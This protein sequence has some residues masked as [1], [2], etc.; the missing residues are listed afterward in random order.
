M[1][2]CTKLHT[3]GK[4]WRLCCIICKMLLY[5]WKS[6]ANFTAANLCRLIVFAVWTHFQKGDV[7]HNREKSAHTHLDSL[8]PCDVA[9]QSYFQQEQSSLMSIPNLSKC[10]FSTGT[11]KQD[12]K[13]SILSKN[14]FLLHVVPA[15]LHLSASIDAQGCNPGWLH[16]TSQ[17]RNSSLLEA[18]KIKRPNTRNQQEIYNWN[19]KIKGY[20]GL[21]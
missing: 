16:D 15:H 19:W 13:A 14:V 20:R 8:W 21:W 2:A 5:E 12:L 1:A 7:L 18:N 10:S 3:P 17:A 4:V 6:G 9:G 11:E